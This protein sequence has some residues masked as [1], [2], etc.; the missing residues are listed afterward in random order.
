MTPQKLCRKSMPHPS[1]ESLFRIA[2]PFSA[3]QRFY[4]K[5]LFHPTF[6]LLRVEWETIPH[7]SQPLFRIAVLSS[8][9]QRF[10]QKILYSP[11]VP[12]AS[13]RVGDHAAPSPAVAHNSGSVFNSS[14]VL[15]E[16]TSFTQRSCC[17][18]LSGRPCRTQINR[19]FSCCF[20]WPA[21]FQPI[22]PAR[23]LMGSYRNPIRM[24]WRPRDLSFP[25]FSK[26]F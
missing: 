26:F 5:N 22:C 8:A 14:K 13:S 11:N 25:V 6:L 10:Y 4:R 19:C 16:E 21:F 12:A 18:E 3:V 20:K 1:P 17:F 15:S 2:F 7:L 9:V 24:G 23:H